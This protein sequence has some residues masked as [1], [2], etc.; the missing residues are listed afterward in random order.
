MKPQK[1][2]DKQSDTEQR[3]Q[4]WEHHNSWF[5]TVLQNYSNWNS[6]LLW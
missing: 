2:L 5:Q 1:P 3:E 6:M 4:S